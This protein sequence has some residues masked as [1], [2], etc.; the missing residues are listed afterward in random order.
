M[1]N[2]I[3]TP[4]PAS[5]WGAEAAKVAANED[6]ARDA[7]D[8]RDAVSEYDRLLARAAAFRS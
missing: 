8:P 2:S 5:A 1:I 4:H 3:T 7:L 6:F